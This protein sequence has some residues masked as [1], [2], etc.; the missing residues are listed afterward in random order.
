MDVV[1]GILA[2][3]FQ[4]MISF[5]QRVLELGGL[6]QEA[7]WLS[8]GLAQMAEDLVGT[9]FLAR[10]DTTK[11][12]VY[13]SG[14]WIRAERYVRDPGSVSLIVT[15][16][17]GSLA[18]RGGGWMF[19]RYLRDQRGSD[20]ILGELTRTTRLGVANVTAVSGRS[21]ESQFPDWSAALYLDGAGV[22][23][24]RA[25]TF[26]DLDLRSVIEVVTTPYPLVPTQL[27]S[28]DFAVSDEL[29][30]SASDFYLVQPAEG[31]TVSLALAGAEQGPSSSNARLHL[32][33]VR[34]R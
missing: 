26:P 28:Q 9:A 3:E 11:A 19:V 33:L 30:S 31:G 16:G 5:N 20:A 8:E 6:T 21:W 13:K 29:W 15:Q 14:N 22:G 7:L 17:D 4:H 10:G 24:D 32:T 34:I 2:H 23:V 18:E 25:L 27:G 12:V 1:P